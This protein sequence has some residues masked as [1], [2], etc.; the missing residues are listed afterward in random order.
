MSPKA[1]VT[2]IVVDERRCKGCGICIALCPKQVLALKK[3]KCRVERLEVCIGCDLCQL[4]C[5]D[6][7]IEVV[8]E[9]N[10]EGQGG[11]SND[12]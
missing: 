2:K 7:A 4:R 11:E 9:G 12:G 5:P 6:F 3:Q 8:H 1:K 10:D